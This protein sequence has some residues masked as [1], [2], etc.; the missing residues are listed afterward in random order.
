M[1][2]QMKVSRAITQLAFRKETSFYG[3]ILLSVG[4]RRDDSIDTMCTDG[5]CVLW[6]GDFTDSITPD[7]V[8]G[9]LLHEAMHIV[10]KHMLRLG[11]RDF[12]LWNYATDYVINLQ[13]LKLGLPLPDGG[14]ISPIFGGM[15]AEKVYQ[16][17]LDNAVQVDAMPQWGYFTSPSK[18]PAEMKQIEASIDQKIMMAATSARARG[19]LPDEVQRLI[20]EME[21]TTVD[22]YDVLKRSIGG[23][24]PE[25][26]TFSRPNRRAYW[27][28]GVITPS[29]R[30][31]NVGNVV[32]AVDSSGSVSSIE[33]SKFLSILND[34]ADDMKP[35][36]VTVITCDTQ[37]K[38]V[39]RY[40]RGE[41]I[42]E[43][44]IGGRGGTNCSPVFEI[45]EREK[46]HVD[47]M[48]YLTDMEIYDYPRVGPDYPVT[49]VSCDTSGNPAPFGQTTYMN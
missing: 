8:K 43:I 15:N 27:E 18:S 19:S 47:H 33:L 30:K 37:V 44:K 5:T 4:V 21:R 35:E 39:T 36:S 22:L 29:V 25:D 38:N 31:D 20:T 49:W 10:F 3:S 7:E 9:V 46:M 14:L 26:L 32:V 2:A 16:H 34:L 6:G 48:I 45:I 1:D 17:L 42:R 41:E 40:E 12:K 24:Q 11:T 23:D 28:Q 13:V